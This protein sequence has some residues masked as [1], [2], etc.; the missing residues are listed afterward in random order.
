MVLR[1][2]RLREVRLKEHA[3]ERR[4]SFPDLHNINN[5]LLTGRYNVIN[6]HQIIFWTRMLLLSVSF[7][8]N[9]FSTYQY[10]NKRT[11]TEQIVPVGTLY[12]S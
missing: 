8:V 6:Q 4:V 9:Y 1:A 5:R 10:Y 7:N 12:S 2:E 3:I 11:L